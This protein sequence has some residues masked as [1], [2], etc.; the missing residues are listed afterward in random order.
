[1][2]KYVS[3]FKSLSLFSL[4]FHYR[5]VTSVFTVNIILLD[6]PISYKSFSVLAY[7]NKLAYANKYRKLR[8]ECGFQEVISYMYVVNSSYHATFQEHYKK[9]KNK[10]IILKWK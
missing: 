1:M 5:L 3:I 4:L 6:S 9:A 8:H 10:L 7:V 2:F